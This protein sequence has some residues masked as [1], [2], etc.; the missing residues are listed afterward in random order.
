MKAKCC[1]GC[2]L[3]ASLERNFCYLCGD[4]LSLPKEFEQLQCGR[5]GCGLLDDY[6]FCSNCGLSREKAIAG[7]ELELENL[8]LSENK[9]AE[10]R[11]NNAQVDS[12]LKKVGIISRTKEAPRV[13]IDKIK[14]AIKELEGLILS[15]PPPFE[16]R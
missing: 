7:D 14:E 11:Q 6:R 3:L 15:L 4:K 1:P 8:N 13:Q 9:K 5:C 12:I 10:I 16:K 2:K